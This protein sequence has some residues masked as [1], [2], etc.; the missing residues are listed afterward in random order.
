VN[1]EIDGCD[2]SPHAI[3]HARRR[4]HEKAALVHFF[5][6]DAAQG[7]LPASYDAVVCSLFLH[8]L[9]EAEAVEMLRRMARA[10]QRLVLVNDLARS[11][12]GFALAYLGT[13]I[14]SAS[15]VVHTDGPRSV[16]AA[17]T[18]EEIRCLAA[19][20]GL[21]GAVVTSRWPCRLLLTWKRT[22]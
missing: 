6:W 9:D 4:A 7:D 22:S 21:E 13:R 16:A 20:A 2:R 3:A 11:R 18:P 10:A 17:F 19:H 5:E 14:L 15:P 1:V 8:H 12:A